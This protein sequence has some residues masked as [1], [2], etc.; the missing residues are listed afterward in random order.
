MLPPTPTQ[1]GAF[2]AT[3]RMIA[4]RFIHTTTLLFDGRVLITGGDSSYA[5]STNAESSAELFDSVAGTFVL[6][7]SMTTPRDGHSATLLPNGKVLIAGGGPRINGRGYSLASAEL[8]DPATGTFSATGSMT[9][10]R[11]FHTATL[12]ND[13]KVLIA[14]G[15]RIVIGGSPSD[16]T[17]PTSAE[18]YDPATGTFTPTG[19][20]HGRF[21]D[22][23]TLLADGKVLI[24][25][26]N[27]RGGPTSAPPNSTTLRPANS[28]LRDT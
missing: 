7:G 20:T 9:V 16:V 6:T 18:L 15:L 26:G 25:S 1:S 28:P 3:G 24:T 8:Y 13:G 5:A 14:G 27:P 11:L 17:F 22:T 19:D 23:A 2:V 12:L 4:P 10:E 21:V